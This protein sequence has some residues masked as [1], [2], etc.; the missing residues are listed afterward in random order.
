MGFLAALPAI[1]AIAAPILGG[2]FGGGQNAAAGQLNTQA[3]NAYGGL[4]SDYQPYMASSLGV[5]NN[6]ATKGFSPQTYSAGMQRVTGATDQN[7]AAARN[8]IG[9]GV[10]NMKALSG[11]MLDAGI[12]GQAD[13]SAQLA[14]ENQQYKTAAAGQLASMGTQ[15]TEAGA[16][17][18]AGL[19]QTYSSAASSAGNPFMNMLSVLTGMGPGGSTSNGGQSF[20]QSLM[21]LFGGGGSGLSP[22]STVPPGAMSFGPGTPPASALFGGVNPFG[23]DGLGSNALASVPGLPPPSYPSISGP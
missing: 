5:L 9:A 22:G 1:S 8:S 15:A 12:R 16:Q 6:A 17:G 10:P 21:G 18:L 4:V 3:A 14:G 2:I 20:M 11:D 19:G 23:G 7:I 13:V